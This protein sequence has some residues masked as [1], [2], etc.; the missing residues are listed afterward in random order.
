MDIK[1][2]VMPG[3]EAINKIL[4]YDPMAN[5][6][7]VTAYNYTTDQLGVPVLRKGFNRKKFLEVIREGMKKPKR[8]G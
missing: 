1:M 2:P 8:L 4:D 6:V 5:I 7:A 3:D